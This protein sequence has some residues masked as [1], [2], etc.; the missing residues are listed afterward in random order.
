M[1]YNRLILNSYYYL[2]IISAQVSDYLSPQPVS[3]SI[4][5]F[6]ISIYIFT[7]RQLL[8][9]VLSLC[10]PLHFLNNKNNIASC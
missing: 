2:N 3:S 6:L 5:S 1:Y 4:I 10:H 9:C 8:A 7:W